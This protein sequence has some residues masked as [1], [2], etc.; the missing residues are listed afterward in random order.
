MLLNMLLPGV[1]S[2]PS[3][4]VAK[5]AQKRVATNKD[6][7]KAI[8]H[9]DATQRTKIGHVAFVPVTVLRFRPVEPADALLDTF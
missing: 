1:K 4:G 3:A 2:G 8:M 7:L 5:N 6:G 9:L